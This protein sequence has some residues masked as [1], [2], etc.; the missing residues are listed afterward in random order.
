MPRD[1]CLR[2]VIVVVTDKVG[3]RVFGEEFLEL[4]IQLRGEGLVVRHDQGRLLQL[5]D[6]RRDGKGFAGAGGA[7]Q[8]LILFACMDAIHK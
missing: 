2:L 8:N 3:D 7:E 6:H 5:L 1:I 4:G